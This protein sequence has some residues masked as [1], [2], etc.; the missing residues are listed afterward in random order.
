MDGCTRWMDVLDNGWGFKTEKQDEDDN[1][2]GGYAISNLIDRLEIAFGEEAK[3]EVLDS[4]RGTW[5]R[6]KLPISKNDNSNL[7]SNET[8]E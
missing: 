1:P 3:F 6:L 2:K 5:I 7:I 8:G 4:E